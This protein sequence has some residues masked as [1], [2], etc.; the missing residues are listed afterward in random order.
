MASAVLNTVA[1]ILLLLANAFFVA[2]EFALVR[3]RRFR[4]ESRA[5]QGS[6]AARLTLRMLDHLEAYLAACQLGITMAS[7]GL[8]WVGEPAVAALL[9]PAFR[10]LGLSDALL[11]TFAFL[12]GFLLFSS[13]HIVVGEQVPKTFAI[14]QAEP[15]ALAMAYPLQ[16]FY[17][18]W[19]PLNWLLNR[20]SQAILSGFGVEQATHGDVLTSEELREYIVASGTHGSMR[21]QERDM[22][23]GILDLEEVEVS[24][25]MTHRKS[26]ETIDA[27]SPREQILEQVVASPHSRLP[28]WRGDPDS[29]IGVLNG[30][31]LFAAVHRYGR[32]LEGVDLLA[33][34]TSPW[35]IP[36]TTPLRKQLVAFRQRHQHLA[37]VVNEY[38]DLE[39]LVTL[40][41]II[42][43]IVGEIADER[44]VEPVGI[45]EQRDG[46][47]LVSGWITVRDLNRQ[48][49]WR[50]PDEE[51]ATVAGLVINEAQR[52]P[53]VGQSFAFHGFRFEVLR[54][55]RNQIVLLRVI[56]PAAAA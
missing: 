52:I 21:K 29:I 43:E 12:A 53:E 7:L 11:H 56:P 46:S 6:G 42:E 22:L 37:L 24:E 32:K 39:G 30:K 47:V 8:G 54:R 2:A 16:L 13:L 14:R 28:V 36:D 44:D 9:E 31:D 1:V 25:I 17:L 26:M 23:G 40:E 4:I 5:E 10:A 20:A 3:V 49:D 48:F 41:D 55:Q 50:L 33:L 27:D 35:F 19:F 34:C 18:L 38:G 45:E 51:A 15:M